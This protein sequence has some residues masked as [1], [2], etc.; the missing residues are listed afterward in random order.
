M[1]K[2]I[3][4]LFIF[5]INISFS[6]A[7][8]IVLNQ[9]DN[10]VIR[11]SNIH[12]KRLIASITKVM[13]AYIVINN[14]NL[15]DLVEA[16]DEIDN[17]HGSSIY[18]VK[19]EK[20]TVEELLYGMM[21]RSGNDAA[22]VLANYVG[23]SVDNFVNLMNEEVKKLGL[24]DTVFMN[25]TGL[26]DNVNGNISSAY[27]MA[28][29]TNSAMKNKVFR[30]IF[31][32]K[33]YTCKSNI[34]SFDWYNKNKTLYKY[35]YITGGKTGY[36]KK[37]R[38][39]LITT[40]SKNN[41]NLTMVTLNVNDDFNF[42]IDNYKSIFD[43]YQ[44]YL[45]INKYDLK[46]KDKMYK[47]QDCTFFALNNYYL[48]GKKDELKNLSIEYVINKN[49]KYKPNTII[50]NVNVYKKGNIVFEEPIYINCRESLY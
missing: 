12:E 22:L 37:A 10:T 4:F 14:S 8:Y 13:T 1:K 27:D 23:G 35:K 19:G 18:L 34:K 5:F 45:I 26:D 9:D 29:I 32:T 28:I 6:K 24:E 38:R 33:H 3:V 43:Y 50:G 46:I 39:T 31:K 11:G 25:P 40:A 47:N 48:L 16:G 41:I 7:S 49:H 30:K 36:T 42:H 44:K 15:N 20:L 21:L 2:I 17:A